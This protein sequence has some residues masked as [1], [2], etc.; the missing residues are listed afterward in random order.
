MKVVPLRDEHAEAIV[1]W[2][3]DPP[4]DVY[5]PAGDPDEV[6]LLRD[7]ARRPGLRAVFEADALLGYFNF[8]RHGDEIHAGL[9]LR[10]DLTGRGLGRAFVSAGLAYATRE[11]APARFRLWVAAFNA[12]AI[13]V[14]EQVGFRRVA[15]HCR[16]RDRVE[17]IEMGRDA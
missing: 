4:Y 12:R 16:V 7:P 6:D 13:R 8:L 9:A 2:R 5:D 11:W 1:G 14:Y 15:G 10:P 3:Y 17:F